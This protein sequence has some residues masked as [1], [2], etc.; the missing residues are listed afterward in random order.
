METNIIK[1][2]CLDFFGMPGSGKSTI[3]HTVAE[4][5]RQRNYTVFEP[6]YELDHTMKSFTRKMKK[7]YIVLSF[8]I[9]NRQLCKQIFQSIFQN[10][11][12]NTN[13]YLRYYF[14]IILKIALLNRKPLS[15]FCIFDEGLCQAVISLSI[16]RSMNTV[17]CYQQLHS[18]IGSDISYIPI[19]L[20]SREETALERMFVRG[21]KDSR[22]EKIKDKNEQ[23]ALLRAFEIACNTFLPIDCMIIDSDNTEAIACAEI[24]MNAVFDFAPIVTEDNEK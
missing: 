6:S 13:D 4:K 7:L 18:Y 19:Y 8:Y 16:N 23:I 5:L 22:V 3:S 15:E 21:S 9:K 24:I 1:M 14:N 20:Q 10:N 12:L 17:D 11:G 2:V